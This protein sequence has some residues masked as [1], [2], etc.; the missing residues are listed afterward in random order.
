MDNSVTIMW[1]E[2][3][4]GSDEETEWEKSDIRSRANSESKFKGG[5]VYV[6]K[7]VYSLRRREEVIKDC[8]KKRGH[9]L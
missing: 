1:K 5:K 2:D 8:V 9:L 7:K 4:S 6:T 3:R